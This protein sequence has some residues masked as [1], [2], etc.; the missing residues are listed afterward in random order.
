MKLAATVFLSLS[1]TP[2]VVEDYDFHKGGYEMLLPIYTP[3]SYNW[4]QALNAI[5]IVETGSQRND[6][7]GAVGDN[8]K[9]LGPYQI[10]EV[11]WRDAKIKNREYKEVLND[12]KLSEQVIHNYMK[13]YQRKSLKRLKRGIGNLKD[14]ELISRTHNG[15]PQGLKKEATVSYFH[16]VREVLYGPRDTFKKR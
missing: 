6:G 7:I 10:W 1:L 13:R 14:I 15:G 2:A 5:R 8:G 16:K 11:Y 12:K 3:K 9:A 4:K